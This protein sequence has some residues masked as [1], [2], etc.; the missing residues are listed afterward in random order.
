VGLIPCL[1]RLDGGADISGTG[2]NLLRVV[3]HGIKIF[4]QPESLRHA[5]TVAAD[6]FEAEHR[7]AV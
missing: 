4:H 1:C 5:V 7:I 6:M 3:N 2:K